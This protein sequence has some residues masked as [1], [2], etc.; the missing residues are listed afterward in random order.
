MKYAV[1]HSSNTGN[2][3]LLT[4]RM[5]PDHYDTVLSHSEFPIVII[6]KKSIDAAQ[7]LY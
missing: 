4:D 1:V 6:S 2:T 3:A 7:K 5:L